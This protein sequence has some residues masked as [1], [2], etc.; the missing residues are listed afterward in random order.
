MGERREEIRRFCCVEESG[1]GENSI[2]LWAQI[3]P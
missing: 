3:G 2:S 1:D